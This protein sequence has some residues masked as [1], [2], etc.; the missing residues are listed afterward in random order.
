MKPNGAKRMVKMPDKKEKKQELILDAAF[1]LMLKNGY[2]NTKI[3]D[4]ANKAGIGKGTF[5]EYFESKEAL[6]LK[7]IDTRVSRDYAKVCE[8]MESAGTCKQK[9]ENYFRL[10]IDV[11]SKY[12]TNV[13]DF[14][15]EFMHGNTEI[16]TK[17]IEATHG[18]MRFQLER[19]FDVIK[20]GI[21]SGEFKQTDPF[22][23]A[24]CFMGSISFYMSLLHHEATG[25]SADG[26]NHS[27]QI[28]NEAS[29]LDCIF[30]G[31]LA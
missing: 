15:N 29:F 12:Q 14:I 31:L 1:E 25:F 16:S 19:V 22:A 30:N 13:T 28:E 23:A 5:Y 26:F 9:L 24:I 10:E 3:I 21:E 11:T 2:S 20:K 18:I 6:V 8:A 7:L 17:I 4:I 27:I